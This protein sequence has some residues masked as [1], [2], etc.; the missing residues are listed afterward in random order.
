MLKLIRAASEY[1]QQAEIMF[2]NEPLNRFETYVINSQE[3]GAKLVDAVNM[4]SF[5]LHYDTFHANIEEKDPG[6]VIKRWGMSS[7]MCIFPKTIA[8]LRARGRCTERIFAAL[9]DVNYQGWLVIELLD[10]RCLNRCCHLHLAA[11][12]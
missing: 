9:K 2:T 4:P 5:K 10:G 7:V 6:A 12:V 3:D 11:D 1:A 8:A